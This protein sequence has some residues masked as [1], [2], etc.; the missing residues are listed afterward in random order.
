M[1]LCTIFYH[2]FEKAAIAQCQ[3]QNA[4]VKGKKILVING[5]ASY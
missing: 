3:L 2:T 5:L 1:T 4:T